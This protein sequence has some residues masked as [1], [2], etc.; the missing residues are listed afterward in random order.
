MLRR[1]TAQAGSHPLPQGN[2]QLMRRII[3]GPDQMLARRARDAFVAERDPSGL[4]VDRFDASTSAGTFRDAL[5]TVGFFG[6]GRVVVASGLIERLQKELSGRK[7]AGGEPQL[8]I[9][10]LSTSNDN[11]LLLYDPTLEKLPAWLKSGLSPDVTVEA[12]PIPRGRDLIAWVKR[13]AKAVGS[14]IDDAAVQRLLDRVAPGRWREANRNPAFDVPP[15]LLSLSSEI[16]KLADYAEGA[17]AVQHVEVLV[18]ASEEDRM[19]P[20]I[21]AITTGYSLSTWRELATLDGD[22]DVGRAFNLIMTT[23]ELG[24]VTDSAGAGSNL[25]EVARELGLKNPNRLT[26]VARKGRVVT[27]AQAAKADR[28]IKTG[29]VA[30]QQAALDWIALEAR[31]GPH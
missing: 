20:L 8:L 17:I 11:T 7:P 26:Q 1:G 19:F 28:L 12:F 3:L 14:N 27:T 21:D 13:E 16:A 15:D 23:L 10:A 18:A 29:R 2:C 25:P 22:D 6:S 5:A 30:S 4:S 9:D 31:R 24:A